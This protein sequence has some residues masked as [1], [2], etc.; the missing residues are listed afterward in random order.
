MD[1]GREV[2]SNQLC[3]NSF[4][5]LENIFS[6]LR[7]VVLVVPT[8]R[9]RVSWSRRDAAMRPSD[10]VTTT[11][12]TTA[13]EG[14]VPLV[15]VEEPER[16]FDRERVLGRDAAS[17]FPTLAQAEAD[18]VAGAAQAVLGSMNFVT[19]T[20]LEEIK[21]RRGGTLRVEDGTAE[22]SK[23]LWAVLQE[24]KEAK[25]EAFAQGWK[26]IKQGQNKPLDEEEI[27]FLDEVEDTAREEERRRL[28]R[29]RDDVE[30]FRLARETMVVKAAPEPAPPAKRARRDGLVSNAAD[31]SAASAPPP[32]RPKPVARAKIVAVR[33]KEGGG[34]GDGGAA[35]ATGDAAAETKTKDEAG[36]DGG[37]LG[38][39][40][41]YGSGSD[42]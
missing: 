7:R 12:V 37:G 29:E 5:A 31:A 35:N 23:P 22:A 34:E 17:V 33:R 39:L 20:E 40:L 41:G 14:G 24:A 13:A 27:E 8:P 18:K 38:G 21:E 32:K 4:Q 36:D 25:E 19:E 3:P 30:T 28:E 15:R 16:R 42:S 2:Q 26:T 6:R 9:A 10:D 11:A 1:S